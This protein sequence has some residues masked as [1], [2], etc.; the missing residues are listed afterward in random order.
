M[1]LIDKTCLLA[2]T[3]EMPKVVLLIGAVSA[4]SLLLKQAFERL[5]LPPIVG[6]LLLGM[7]V[8]YLNRVIP[9]FDPEG[10]GGTVLAFVSAATCLGTVLFLHWALR[11]WDGG[12]E[13]DPTTGDHSGRT[14]LPSDPTR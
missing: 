7:L 2:A 8:A 11:R 10:R 12:K 9:L 6:Y 3:G 1:A 5:S 4:A 14:G 13:G